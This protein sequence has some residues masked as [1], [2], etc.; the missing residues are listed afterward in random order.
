M[1]P[2]HACGAALAALLLAPSGALA[3]NPSSDLQRE[4]DS[5]RAAVAD[6]E[7]LDERRAVS[8]E[9]ALLRSFYDEAGAWLAKQEWDRV[10]EVLDR[11]NAQSELIRQKSIAT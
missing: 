4:I 6:L 5:G 7:R 8:D 9:T 3:R 2:S 11:C 1:R 10:R